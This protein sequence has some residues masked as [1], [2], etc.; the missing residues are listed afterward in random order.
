MSSVIWRRTSTM[1]VS[2]DIQ[3]GG[4]LLFQF[5]KFGGKLALTGQHL[6]HADEGTHDEDA[7]LQWPARCAGR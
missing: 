3:S 6:A 4:Q 7:H 5:G 2:W 1:A